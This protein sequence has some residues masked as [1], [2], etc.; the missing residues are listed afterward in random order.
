MYISVHECEIV[1]IIDSIISTQGSIG[2]HFLSMVLALL[3]IPFT[4]AYRSQ[5]SNASS[6]TSSEF[7]SQ[8]SLPY[9]YLVLLSQIM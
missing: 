9:V 4:T 5:E 8:P 7:N 6:L 2:Y 3:H 1:C